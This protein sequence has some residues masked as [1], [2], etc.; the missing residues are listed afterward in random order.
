LT[1]LGTA[2]I[3]KVLCISPPLLRLSLPPRFLLVFFW[4][5]CSCLILLSGLEQ[6]RDW[7]LNPPFSMNFF[8]FPLLFGGFSSLIDLSFS[9]YD[10]VVRFTLPPQSFLHFFVSSARR[11]FGLQDDFFLLGST[12]R[13]SFPIFPPVL[14][15]RLFHPQCGQHF[16]SVNNP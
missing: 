10:K 1:G 11:A 13:P 2:A 3:L 5:F 16:Y 9:H 14:I 7:S 15:R 12:G 6:K 4:Y 8:S